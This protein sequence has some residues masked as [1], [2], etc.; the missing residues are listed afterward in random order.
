MTFPI[1]LRYPNLVIV[2]IKICLPKEGASQ[3]TIKNRRNASSKHLKCSESAKAG[4]NTAPVR[5][6]P[7]IHFK[8]SDTKPCILHFLVTGNKGVTGCD[9]FVLGT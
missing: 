6:P 9:Y 8:Q 7:V 3:Y 1:I 4:L 5:L 2:L